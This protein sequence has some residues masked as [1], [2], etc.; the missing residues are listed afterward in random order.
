MD[1]S[2][3]PMEPTTAPDQ[4]AL[5]LEPSTGK[6]QICSQDK[7]M[8][9]FV[10]FG[11]KSKLC[12]ISTSKLSINGP[13]SKLTRAPINKSITIVAKQIQTP[14]AVELNEM[15]VELVRFGLTAFITLLVVVDPPGI[16]P[17]FVAFNRQRRRRRAK[18]H[19]HARGHDR[20]YRRALFFVAGRS[21]LSLIWV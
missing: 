21:V 16:V 2:M 8:T 15:D 9:S 4:W 18:G 19:G 17:V 3:A 7:R 5:V 6:R 20:L 13:E 12:R 11:G 1:I 14:G 10:L